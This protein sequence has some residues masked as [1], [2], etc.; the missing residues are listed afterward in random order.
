MRAKSGPPPGQ[1]R[2][3]PRGAEQLLQLNRIYVTEHH[4]ISDSNFIQLPLLAYFV[5]VF[6]LAVGA[7]ARQEPDQMRAGDH[8]A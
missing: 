7:E 3:D 5:K 1:S 6:A 8:L 2:Q 4:G